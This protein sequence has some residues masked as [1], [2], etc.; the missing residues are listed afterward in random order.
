LRTRSFLIVA[1][2][3][4]CGAGSDSTPPQSSQAVATVALISPVPDSLFSIPDSVT[5]SAEARSAS[6]SV[7]SGATISWTSSDAAVVGVSP[8]SGPST[9]IVGLRG[10]SATITARSGTVTATKSIVVSQRVAA[11]TVSSPSADTLFSIGDTRTLSATA[12]DSRGT[13][14]DAP[15]IQWTVDKATVAA[16]SPTSGP[17][18]TVTAV[19]S[20][21]AVLTA[22]SAAVAATSGVAVRQRVTRV[23]AAPAT[24]TVGV[25]ATAQLSA[26]PLDARGNAVAGLPAPTYVSSDSTKAQVSAAG[27]VI[28]VAPGTATVT[29]SVQTPDGV[30]KAA[31]AVT[32]GFPTF[33]EAKV[34]DFQFN[35][36]IVDVAAGGQV[37]WTWAGSSFHSVTSTGNGPLRSP[38]QGSGTYTF[39][40]PTPGRFDFFCTVH[41]FMTGSV[42]VH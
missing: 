41:P 1:A 10:G 33:A 31:V 14:I 15:L 2:A 22:R 7:V 35:P 28:G 17:T 8:S 32:I 23:A 42:I 29:V 38:T 26:T 3:L 36:M 25:G 19:S 18:T 39:T 21:A 6:G 4:G 20:G 12:R 9:T 30:A 37:R 16:I 13:T 24:I 40:F 5:V 27:L 11:L 34:E